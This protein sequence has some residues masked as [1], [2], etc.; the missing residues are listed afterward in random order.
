MR[1]LAVWP[2]AH[3][4]S[5]EVSVWDRQGR[6][7]FPA[8]RSHGSSAMLRACDRVG[9]LKKIMRRDAGQLA[10]HD[11]LGKGIGD[12]P[13]TTRTTALPGASTPGRDLRTPPRGVDAQSR[14]CIT[15]G[16]E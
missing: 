16:R 12:T 7:T 2:R 13:L 4:R 3:V 6:K 9:Q 5:Q 11:N 1:L 14:A 8:Y 15:T 10:V